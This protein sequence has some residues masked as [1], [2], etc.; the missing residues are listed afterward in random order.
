MRIRFGRQRAQAADRAP[1]PAGRLAARLPPPPRV[2][3][4]ALLLT[5]D[6]E[7]EV[8][9]GG[10]GGLQDDVEAVDLLA[11]VDLRGKVGEEG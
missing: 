11:Q 3:S 2:P 1:G 9:E 5:G 8:C 7:P 6:G 10:L 4:H